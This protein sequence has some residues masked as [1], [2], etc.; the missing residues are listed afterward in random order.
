MKYNKGEVLE[1]LLE[2][3]AASL[4]QPVI[5]S[6]VKDISGARRAERGYIDDK[7]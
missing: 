5:Y 2:P 6:V 1:A 7:F 4:I 3:S